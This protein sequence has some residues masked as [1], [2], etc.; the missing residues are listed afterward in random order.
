MD[1]PTYDFVPE[2]CKGEAPA[3]TGAVVLKDLTFDQACELS[4]KMTLAASEVHESIADTRKVREAVKL[5][6]DLVVSVALVRARDS[7]TFATWDELRACA[8]AAVPLAQIA[9]AAVN[10]GGPGNG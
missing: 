2:C 3:W 6:K 4:E 8:G 7:K 9:K 1:C 10:G 5:A